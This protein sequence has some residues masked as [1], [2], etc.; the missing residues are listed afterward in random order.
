MFVNLLP[1]N[2]TGS[3]STKVGYKIRSSKKGKFWTEGKNNWLW[4]RKHKP[5]ER[6]ERNTECNQRAKYGDPLV[7]FME[8]SHWQRPIKMAFIELCGGFYTAPIGWC[9]WVP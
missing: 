3:G 6:H 7:H 1:E 5:T 8:C 2:P 9:H 4:R